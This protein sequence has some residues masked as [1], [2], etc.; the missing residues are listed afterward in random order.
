MLEVHAAG[1]CGTDLHIEQGEYGCVPP[2][3][4][5]HEVCGTVAL[6]G[7]GVD[8]A[9][10][11][12]RVVIETYFSTCE[13]CVSCRTGRRNL[14]AER[15]SI[16]THVD[17]GF[18]PRIAVPAR[19]LHSVPETVGDAAATLVEPLAC[20]C[21][22]LLSP[23]RVEPGA[24]VLVSGPGPVG[25]LAAQVAALAGG[26]VVVRGAPR[27]GARL[28]IAEELGLCTVVVG[29]EP[30]RWSGG[31]DRP[32]VTVECSGSDGGIRAALEETRPGGH[33][34][35]IGLRGADVAVPVDLV[36]LR[37]LTVTG[38]MAS[39]TPAWLRAV[40]LVAS[41]EIRLEPLVGEIGP[42]EAWERLF[43]ATRDAAGGK[44]VI[45]PR[46]AAA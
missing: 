29:G 6:L 8:P 20:V 40:G 36:S 14:C 12:R 42:L 26:E 15:R 1:I 32:D 46:R 44:F 41:G 5:G 13:S 33:V 11:G 30:A 18:A 3:T 7:E 24:T 38:T 22:A 43:A 27:D 4:L 16:G 39:T 28:R 19:N 34:V 35:Q 37:E 17:G 2:V 31:R 23:P 45:D 25:L 21:N 9:W 10:L